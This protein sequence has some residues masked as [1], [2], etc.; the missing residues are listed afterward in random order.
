MVTT[1]HEKDFIIFVHFSNFY[2][3][4]ITVMRKKI[5]LSFALILCVYFS[6]AQTTNTV[7]TKAWSWGEYKIGLQAPTDMVVK[8]N[9]ATVFYAGNEHVFLTIYPKKGENLTQDKLPQALQKW[10]TDHK[11][12]FSPSNSA[13]LSSLNRLW[14]YY[15][16]GSGYKGMSTYVSVLVDSSHPEDSYYVWLQYQNGYADVAMN[17]L[18]SFTLE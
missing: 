4:N 7:Q 17:I 1:N 8:E 13:S 6:P 11:I 5:S 12:K 9:S 14:G 2:S 3:Q 18:N 10:G 16:N 15:I